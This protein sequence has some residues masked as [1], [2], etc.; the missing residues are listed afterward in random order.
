MPG[1]GRAGARGQRAGACR[2][3]L[4]GQQTELQLP[5]KRR[6]RRPEPLQQPV[7]SLRPYLPLPAEVK[8]REGAH[9]TFCLLHALAAEFL[10]RLF[11][12]GVDHCAKDQLH[13]EE[14][15]DHYEG[16]EKQQRCQTSMADNILQ[17]RLIVVLGQKQHAELAESPNG[18]REV[19]C[20]GATQEPGHGQRRGQQQEEEK[21]TDLEQA[22]ANPEHGH[23][24]VAD[25]TRS[26]HQHDRP[27]WP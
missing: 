22:W 13:Q 25:T 15:A 21:C 4:V 6:V 3:V 17:Q 5:L 20:P 16:K 19:L 12:V 1:S 2:L 23:V 8:H 9:Q 10:L 24:E 27:Q 18:A 7:E 11:H 26:E 14:D